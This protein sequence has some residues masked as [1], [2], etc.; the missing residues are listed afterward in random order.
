MD[1]IDLHGIRATVLAGPREEAFT[2]QVD[3]TL[4]L[5]VAGAASQDDLTQTVDYVQVARRI[6]SCIERSDAA[7][8]E[9]VAS[10]VAQS[11][12]LSHQVRRVRVSVS[13]LDAG[14][15]TGLNLE[16]VAVTIEREAP[17][18]SETASTAASVAAGLASEHDKCEQSHRH[19]PAGGNESVEDSASEHSVD[20]DNY[21]HKAVIALS[22][23]IG[24]VQ[25]AMRTA[26]VSLDGV[27]GGQILGISPLYRRQSQGLPD[28]LCAVAI[29]ESSLGP[30]DLA[31]ALRMIE[32]AHGRSHTLAVP[33]YPLGI[34]LVDVDGKVWSIQDMLE[35]QPQALQWVDWTGD[36][37]AL[38]LPQAWQRADILKPWSDLE[39]LAQL[40]GDHPGTI[41]DLAQQAP[42]EGDVNVVSDTWIL[43]GSV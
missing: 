6:V 19:H 2:Y 26:I 27:P 16:Q 32:S 7:L 1:S 10:Q 34:E 11:I 17:S 23:N 13:R 41:I 38:P 5:N 25:E 18:S 28:F 29:V 22:G 33:S 42:H 3:A 37:L 20:D 21:R 39:P 30:L 40:A 24:N 31:S 9:T 36:D 15:G 43:G 14:R 35:A 8:I 4:Y 12:L